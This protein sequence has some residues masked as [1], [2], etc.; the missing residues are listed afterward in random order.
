MVTF[1]LQ[2]WKK[3]LGEEL[4]TFTEG[5]Q[6]MRR[7]TVVQ[8]LLVADSNGLLGSGKDRF[9]SPTAVKIGRDA[10]YQMMFGMSPVYL[11]ESFSGLGRGVMQYKSYPLFQYIKDQNTV[12]NYWNG[13]GV[14][15]NLGRLLQAGKVMATTP[16]A[17]INDKDLDQDAIAMVRMLMTRVWQV[18]YLRQH[19]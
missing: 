5:E 17:R 10:V 2:Y 4:F 16:D 13:G 6:A 9:M 1:K 19:I 3:G 7:E 14:A 12:S 11:G 18:Y 8:A 15:E